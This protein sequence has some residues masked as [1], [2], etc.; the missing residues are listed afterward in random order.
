LVV[1]IIVI[2]VIIVAVAFVFFLVWLLSKQGI[3][4]YQPIKRV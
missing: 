3:G 2:F 1:T 4:C